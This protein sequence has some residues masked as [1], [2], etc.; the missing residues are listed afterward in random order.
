MLPPFLHPDLLRK[1]SHS[2]ATSRGETCEKLLST[3]MRN[4]A[5][6]LWMGLV[7]AMWMGGIMAWPDYTSHAV[8]QST[9]P[10]HLPSLGQGAVLREP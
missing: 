5:N 1:G 8:Q 7:H 10:L 4:T 3:K 2:R 9:N 6:S